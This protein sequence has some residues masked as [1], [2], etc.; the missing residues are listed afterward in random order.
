MCLARCAAGDDEAVSSSR[1]GEGTHILPAAGMI[2]DNGEEL[3]ALGGIA[4]PDELRL[5][6]DAIEDSEVVAVV[7][8][9]HHELLK[10]PIYTGIAI[11]LTPPTGKVR[12]TIVTN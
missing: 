8:G 1:K 12:P 3:P 4:V 10:P 5:R 11:E 7:G 6:V 2:R 9:G